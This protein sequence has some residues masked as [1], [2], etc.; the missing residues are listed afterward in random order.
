MGL[1]VMS[2]KEICVPLQSIMAK[3]HLCKTYCSRPA[4]L[5]HR[6]DKRANTN[7]RE[8]AP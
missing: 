3:S 2:I 7:H 1:K 4:K 8:V 5:P 6:K